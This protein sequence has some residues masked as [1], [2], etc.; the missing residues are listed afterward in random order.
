MFGSRY[1]KCL[2]KLWFWWS[3]KRWKQVYIFKC[4]WTLQRK[5]ICPWHHALPTREQTGEVKV[6]SQAGRYLLGPFAQSG[7]RGIPNMHCRSTAPLCRHV[8]EKYSPSPMYGERLRL[9]N[10]ERVIFSTAAE[11]SHLKKHPF[12]SLHCSTAQQMLIFSTKIECVGTNRLGE[13][14]TF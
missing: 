5:H 6:V 7:H 8:Y 11:F 4:M 2:K 12:V 14:D 1:Q 9:V 13:N 3:N 10:S